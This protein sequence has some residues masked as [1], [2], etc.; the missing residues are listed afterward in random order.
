MCCADESSHWCSTSVCS[1]LLARL[2][3]DDSADCPGEY[4]CF[5]SMLSSA[6]IAT[7]CSSEC[8]NVSEAE[9]CGEAG[10]CANGEAC[11]AFSCGAYDTGRVTLGLCTAT[12][13]EVCE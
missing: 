7:F 12:A 10:D 6:R 1:G 4:C 8:E 3:C 5:S 11:Q 13:P 2:A 9:V